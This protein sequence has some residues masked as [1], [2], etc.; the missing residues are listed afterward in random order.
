VKLVFKYVGQGDSIILHWQENEVNKFIAIDCNLLN[1][2]VP[3]LDYI[4]SFPNSEV[5]AII[6]SHPHTD[7]FSGMERLLKGLTSANIP[8]KYFW[9]TAYHSEAYFTTSVK[10]SD[11]KGKLKRLFE[12]VRKMRDEGRLELA[13]LDGGTPT[14]VINLGQ[15][16]KIFV[17][18]PTS[19][20]QDKYLASTSLPSK[21][22]GANN[23]KA[24][25]LSTVLRIERGDKYYLPTSDVE[26]FTLKG[27]DQRQVVNQNQLAFALGQ[28]PHHGSIHNY[29]N[30][31]WTKRYKEGDS[32][33]AVISSG[34]NGYDHPSPQLVSNL[35]QM[36]Y[37][38][39]ITGDGK[40]LPAPAQ[41]A[42]TSLNV[43]STEVLSS[44]EDSRD[45]IIEL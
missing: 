17:L 41:A 28:I 1:D 35:T 2:Q 34:P 5:A 14:P 22:E 27:L 45:V 18:A 3:T 32:P 42:I 19:R 10:G 44:S 26:K 7:H 29:N 13:S 31:F 37:E 24:N 16:T 39:K 9:H 23:P 20:E 8:I 38:V 36:G 6:L 21:F 15:H 4:T 12:L 30:T 25:W 40:I 33:L 43:F 11:A